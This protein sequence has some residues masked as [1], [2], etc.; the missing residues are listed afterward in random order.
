MLATYFVPF[1]YIGVICCRCCY[2]E[3]ESSLSMAHGLR[4][5][6]NGISIFKYFAATH[7]M[8]EKE[9]K[10]EREFRL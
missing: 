8:R 5:V 9:K 10:T 1:A 4:K 2:F 3:N 7:K 6:F